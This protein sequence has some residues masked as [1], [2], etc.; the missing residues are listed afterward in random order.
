M[1]WY[2]DNWLIL[3]SSHL[4]ALE[5]RDKVSRMCSLLGIVINLEKSSLVPIPDDSLFGDGSGQPVFEGFSDSQADRN[6]PRADHRISVLQA[7]KSGLLGRLTSLCHL[8]PGGRL[9]LRSLQLCLRESW[10]FVD[11]SVSVEWTDMIRSDLLWWSDTS[12]ILA[13]VSLATPHTDHHFWSD[14]SD[15][16]WGTHVGDHFVSGWWS[17]EEIE[18]SINLREL[19]AIRL[20]LQHFQCLLAGSS[21][22]VFAD[23][24]KAL[25]YVRKQG[26]THSRFLNKEARLL[27]WVENQQMLLL[28]QFVM[29]THNMVADS[30]S[31]PNEV[32]GSEWT[33]AQEVV[34][35]LVHRWPVTIDLFAT[36]LNHRLPVYV[37]P[38]AD[39]ASIVTDALLQCWDHLQAYAFPLFRLVRQVLNKFLESANCELTLVA[40]WW[41]QQEWFSDLQRL[42]RFPPIPLP[43]RWDLLRQPHFHHYHLNLRLLGLHAWRL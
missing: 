25:A 8:V 32:I 16:G 42:A 35:H 39:P 6:R 13:R 33:L 2:L 4:E 14:T 20:G 17:Q 19:R 18:M 40:P 21:V 36:A 7:A 1:L 41:P 12:N 29:G 24:T 22:R 9:R 15:Q 5:A 11:E 27:R 10:D 37:A 31:R 23:N 3:A 28:P 26:G 30:L 43:I 38:M 34:D